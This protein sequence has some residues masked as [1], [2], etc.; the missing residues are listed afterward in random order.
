MNPNK[1]E[2]DREGRETADLAWEEVRT[3]HIVQDQW[4]DFR[5]SAYR[6]P[7]GRLFEPFYSYSRKDYVVIVAS[8]EQGNYLCVRQFRQ[9]IKEV[10]TEFPAG[11]IERKDGKEYGTEQGQFVSEDAWKA[12]R[13]ELFEETGY[14]SDEWKHLLTV[15]SNA[16]IADNYAHIFSARKCRKSGK[17]HLDETEFLNVRKYTAAEIEK[18]IYEGGFQQAVHIM[19]WMLSREDFKVYTLRKALVKSYLGKIADIKIDRPAGSIHPKHAD[20]IY[21]VNYGYIPGILGGDGEELDVYLLGIDKPVEEYT[22]RIIAIIHRQDDVED[23]LVM[24]PD[25]MEYTRDAVADQVHFQ[26]QYYKTEIEMWAKK[27]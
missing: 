10:T 4:I 24:A 11:G 13:R 20:I 9:G 19:A 15:P 16:T 27:I 18:L 3:E 12:A 17:Q 2:Y 7:D 21:P 8:D 5:R 26:E 1:E 6:F 25:G 14:E 22:G 23:K